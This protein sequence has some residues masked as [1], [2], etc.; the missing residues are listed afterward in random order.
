MSENYSFEVYD[1]IPKANRVK[2]KLY[3]DAIYKDDPDKK[4]FA[5]EV[6]SKLIGVKN[7]GDL[8]I[9]GKQRARS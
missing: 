8:G 3:V 2:W 4:N 5:A 9:W 1:R 6:F 7:Q